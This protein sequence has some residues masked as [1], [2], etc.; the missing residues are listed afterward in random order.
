MGHKLC[1]MCVQQNALLVWQLHSV[2]LGGVK[3]M[4]ELVKGALQESGVSSAQ[5]T[6]NVKMFQKV[7]QQECEID[8]I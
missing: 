7:K 5:E 6:Q 2:S 3:E 1:V 4:I 8:F